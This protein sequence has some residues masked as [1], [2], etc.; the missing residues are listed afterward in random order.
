MALEADVKPTFFKSQAELRAWFE[1]HHGT[2]AE[3]WIGYYKKGSGKAGVTYRESLDEALRFGWIDG[4]TRSLDEER[5]AI[6]HTPR[7]PKSNWS[8]RNVKRVQ[9]LIRLGRMH[10][11]GLAAF[12]ARKEERTG[13]YSY[14]QRPP[15]LPPNYERKVKANRRAWEFWLS[16][17]PSYRKAATWWVISARRAD[18]RE[19]RLA[20]LIEASAKGERIPPLTGPASARTKRPEG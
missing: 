18:T 12:E 3:L 5:Y 20:T 2:A 11:A 9:E 6:R 10:P 17:A 7:R 19:R 4:L 8:A 13:I 14:E 15:E 1:K 16:V